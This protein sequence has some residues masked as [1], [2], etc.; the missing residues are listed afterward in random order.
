MWGIFLKSGGPTR[1]I[2]TDV[3]QWF[4]V[5]VVVGAIA[6][7]YW[8]SRLPEEKGHP[9]EPILIG[10]AILR[11]FRAM[12]YL[13]NLVEPRPPGKPKSIEVKTSKM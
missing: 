3:F 1:G 8:M 4:F 11:P 7:S 2:N 9:V 6:I 10:N 12:T 5:S 13:V